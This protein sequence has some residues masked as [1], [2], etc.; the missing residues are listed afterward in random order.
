MSRLFT[1]LTLDGNR[2]FGI[3]D[4][5][6]IGSRKIEREGKTFTTEFKQLDLLYTFLNLV[7]GRSRYLTQ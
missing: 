6:R 2:L 5:I 1:V 3:S 7:L 4:K